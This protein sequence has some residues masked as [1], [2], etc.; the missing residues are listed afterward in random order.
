MKRIAGKLKK[1]YDLLDKHFGDLAWWPAD[2]DFEVMVGAMLTQN[3]AW[4]NVEKAIEGLKSSGLLTPAK[5]SGVDLRRLASVIRPAG[6]FR[7]KARR[8]K[9]MCRFLI[10]EC[11]GRIKTLR[12][13]DAASLRKMLLS[14]N[15]I[16]PETADSILIFALEKPVFVVDAYTRRIFSRHGL[17]EEDA[18]YEELQALVRKNFPV[19]VKKLNQFHALIVEASKRYCRKRNPLCEECPLGILLK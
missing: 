14:L 7:V 9:E 6:Y 5:M 17:A 11:G 10:A 3:T 8:L 19:E 1:I 18:S 16:G 15:G 4:S 13:R 2:T 12:K